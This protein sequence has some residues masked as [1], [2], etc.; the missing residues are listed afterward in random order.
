MGHLE[1]M[2]QTVNDFMISR[3]L[4]KEEFINQ[5]AQQQN[6]I[7]QPMVPQGPQFVLIDER[8]RNQAFDGP[9]PQ[10]K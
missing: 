1:K 8:L 7:A 9:R 5:I 3:E 6:Q 10:P 2:K 4:E